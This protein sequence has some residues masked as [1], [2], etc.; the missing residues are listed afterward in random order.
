MSLD[1]SQQEEEHASILGCAW[2][3]KLGFDWRWNIFDHNWFI[4]E[5]P[6]EK[7]LFL[8]ENL[9]RVGLMENGEPVLRLSTKGVRL[10]RYPK[11]FS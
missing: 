7:I 3:A 4:D 5:S 8:E 6:R 10:K 2:A 1:T 9:E 11:V